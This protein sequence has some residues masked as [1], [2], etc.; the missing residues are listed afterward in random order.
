MS[1]FKQAIT[2]LKEGKK[3]RR[4]LWGDSFA[5]WVLRDLSRVVYDSFLTEVSLIIQDI[6]AT[7]WI[8]VRK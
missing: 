6:E 8:E 2:W 7:D 4:E 5:N 1:D 3:V